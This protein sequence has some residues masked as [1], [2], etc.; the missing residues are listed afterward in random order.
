VGVWGVEK[1][2]RPIVTDEEKTNKYNEHEQDEANGKG[3][4]AEFVPAWA[5]ERI[6]IKE[7]VKV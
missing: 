1:F 2:H 7:R 4:R 5:I 3:E 6:Q